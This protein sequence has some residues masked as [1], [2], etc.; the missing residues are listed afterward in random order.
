M[1]AKRRT[2]PKT[3]R[4]S[5]CRST[6]CLRLETLEDRLLLTQYLWTGQ[7][8]QYWHTDDNWIREDGLHFRPD[9]TG[10]AE[11]V[12]PSVPPGA[13]RRIIDDLGDVTF[14]SIT[15]VGP[16]VGEAGHPD[17]TYSYVLVASTANNDYPNEPKST[18]L[19][20]QG[21]VDASETPPP[22][23]HDFVNDVEFHDLGLAG[24]A[25]FSQGF[26]GH[27][28]IGDKSK[29]TLSEDNVTHKLTLEN[30]N[31]SQIASFNAPVTGTGQLVKTGT[32]TWRLISQTSDF[33]AIAPDFITVQGGLLQVFTPQSLG[34]QPNP[35]HANA[36]FLQTGGSLT[37]AAR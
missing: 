2:W 15:F 26:A 22:G 32:G 10:N 33:G 5:R 35:D 11:L 34:Q 8:G 19:L 28:V 20:K 6:F 16:R 13:A 25:I 1:P 3:N 29:V 36:V 9:Q 24:D 30:D 31:N 14:K 17:D 12:F 7:A 37:L 27:L 23:N 21:I 4:R 18:V